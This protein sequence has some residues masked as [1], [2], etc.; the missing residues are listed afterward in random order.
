MFFS[1]LLENSPQLLKKIL[2]L[3]SGGGGSFFYFGFPE[4]SISEKTRKIKWTLKINDGDEEKELSGEASSGLVV[5]RNKWQ[6][7]EIE[8]WKKVETRNRGTLYK[9]FFKKEFTQDAQ[10]LKRNS[11]VKSALGLYKVNLGLSDLKNLKMEE[12]REDEIKNVWLIIAKSQESVYLIPV[13]RS[14]V[15][16][17]QSKRSWQLSESCWRDVADVWKSGIKDLKEWGDG[18]GKGD[19][20]DEDELRKLKEK[21][22]SGFFIR[23]GGSA[24][25]E[26]GIR[27]G[28]NGKGSDVNSLAKNQTGQEYAGP[29]V[30]RNAGILG[31]ELGG[32]VCN[33]SN[34]SEI[35]YFP[36]DIKVLG[37]NKLNEQKGRKGRSPGKGYNKQELKISDN[38]SEVIGIKLNQVIISETTIGN[39]K[40]SEIDWENVS[41]PSWTRE[42]LK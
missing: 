38:I 41:R 25:G 30:Y 26:R 28:M 4:D 36:L 2:I 31:W 9:L 12:V 42:L 8:E 3:S 33:N 21:M 29:I 39:G 17:H 5:D 24:F 1:K 6:G 40:G 11:S 13:I 18:N 27:G 7:L 10:E 14:V 34:N 20:F 35:R 37:K 32:E 16:H 19:V 23:R 15:T 22:S